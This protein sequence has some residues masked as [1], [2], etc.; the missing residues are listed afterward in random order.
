M[1]LTT[2]NGYVKNLHEKYL[3]EFP[4]RKISLAMFCRFRPAYLL[5]NFTSRNV[6]LC[7][8][9]QNLALKLKALKSIQVTG[10]TNPDSFIKVHGDEQ[11]S[12]LLRK[13]QDRT[14]K[15]EIWKKVKLLN[16]MTTKPSEE[17]IKMR[18][19]LV[20]EEQ[21]KEDFLE[22]F[23]SQIKEFREHVLRISTQYKHFRFLKDSLS[24]DCANGFRRKL[25]LSKPRRNPV[26]LLE[27]EECHFASHSNLLQAVLGQNPPGQNPPGQNPPG[28]NPP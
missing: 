18:M 24:A 10:L 1:F 15:Y 2:L 5:V 27:P 22:S 6:C 16:E 19:R 9:H 21:T 17:S 26:Y 3:A 14:V 12:A 23:I 8:R 7:S 20:V 13:I 11:I 4:E 25:Q 28:Q